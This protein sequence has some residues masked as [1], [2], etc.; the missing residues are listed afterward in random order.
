[1]SAAISADAR[2]AWLIGLSSGVTASDIFDVLWPLS[3]RWGGAVI[4]VS[5]PRD[6]V[7]GC[8]GWARV[9]F[10]SSTA[11]ETFA[12]GSAGSVTA[13]WG[14]QWRVLGV[15]VR[16]LDSNVSGVRPQPIVPVEALRTEEAPYLIHSGDTWRCIP[17]GTAASRSHLVGKDHRREA[18]VWLLGMGYEPGSVEAHWAHS[19]NDIPVEPREGWVAEEAPLLDMRERGAAPTDCAG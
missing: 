5:S 14:D 8:A 1:M 19:G 2:E 9:R 3:D 11:A 15:G 18:A 6:A 12:K 4:S 17:C 7:G 10:A 16:A 13:S